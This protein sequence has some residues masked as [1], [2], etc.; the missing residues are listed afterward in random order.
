MPPGTIK[1]ENVLF[2]TFSYLSSSLLRTML[3]PYCLLLEPHRGLLTSAPTF[4]LADFLLSPESSFQKTKLY[5]MPQPKPFKGSLLPTRQSS[6]STAPF[7]APSMACTRPALFS[8]PKLL[9]HSTPCCS[10]KS[11]Y[12]CPL[13]RI[14]SSPLPAWWTPL[15]F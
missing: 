4:S 7:K 3:G 1:P 10:P 13:F 14:S 2:A 15:N 5:A 8:F 6:S 9:P 11:P 12:L